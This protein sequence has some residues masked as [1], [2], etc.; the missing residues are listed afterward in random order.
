MASS[1][2]QATDSSRAARYSQGAMLLDQWMQE[3]SDYDQRVGKLLDG[4]LTQDTK[5][6]EG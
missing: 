2:S 4:G 5:R 6:G 3:H 1:E